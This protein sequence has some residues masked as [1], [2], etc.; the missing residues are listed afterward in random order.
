MTLP[1]SELDRRAVLAGETAVQQ[2]TDAAYK[3]LLALFL[4]SEKHALTCNQISARNNEPAIND[5]ERSAVIVGG[6]AHSFWPGHVHVES[7]IHWSRRKL[8]VIGA[9]QWAAVVLPIEDRRVPPPTGCTDANIL[10]PP[11]YAG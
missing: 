8:P 10:A 9:T 3:A 4:A 2:A 6:Q 7:V 5:K 11:A 1:R